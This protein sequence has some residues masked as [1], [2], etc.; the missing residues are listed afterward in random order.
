MSPAAR[1]LGAGAVLTA[2]APGTASGRPRAAETSETVRPR[3]LSSQEAAERRRL[4]GAN[5]IVPEVRSG[6]WRR[7]A[8]AAAD[9]MVFLLAAVAAVELVL[10]QRRDAVILLIAILPIA[11]MDVFLE[12]KSESALAALRRLTVRR[13][14]A[15][16]DGELL[17]L[18][19]TELV[20]GDRIALQEGD[21]VPADSRLVDSTDIHLDE[22]ALTGESEMVSKQ[23]GDEQRARLFAGT[24]VLSGRGSAVVEI[25]GPKTE[26]GKIARLVSEVEEKPTPLQVLLRRLLR[27]LLPLAVLFCVA[28]VAVERLRG[29]PWP[30][31]ILGGLVLAMA[32]VPEEF[33]V[34]FALFLSLGAFRLARRRALVRELTA[35]E[36]LGAATVACV[37]KTGTLT[38]GRLEA[39]F[40]VGEGGR[41]GPSDGPAPTWARRMLETLLL[42]SE[43]EPYDPVDQALSRLAQAAGLQP[44]SVYGRHDLLREHPFDPREKYHTHT[45]RGEGSA[46]AASKGAPET[47]LARTLAH[48]EKVRMESL[49]RENLEGKTPRWIGVA[50]G[51]VEEGNRTP[52]RSSDESAL[53]LIGFVAFHDRPRPSAAEA[54]AACRSA[55]VR[56]VMITGDHAQ[57][58]LAVAR[59]VGIAAGEEEVLTGQQAERLTPEEFAAA[60]GR[61]HV[62]ARA[63]PELKLRIVEALAAAGETVA[64]T[65][66][67][68]NDAP[69]LKAAAIGVSMGRRGT[70]VAREASR[71]VLLDDDF[72]TLV[73]AIREGRKVFEDIRQAFGYLLAVHVPIILLALLPPVLGWPLL[74]L[75]A[76]IVWI[77]LLIHP[78]SSLVFPFEPEPADLMARPPRPAT[79]GFFAPG[80]AR[81]AVLAGLAITAVS[82]FSFGTALPRGAAFARSQA[83]VTLFACFAVLVL[84]GRWRS[85]SGRRRNRA[86]LPV[87]LGTLVTLPVAL[88]FP[89]L[90]STLGLSPL[91]RESLFLAAALA[92]AFGVSEWLLRRASPSLG[93]GASAFSSSGGRRSGRA[94]G[95]A[96]E[97]ARAPS[98]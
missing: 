60:C 93:R 89:W 3:G 91:S 44:D 7:V 49:W 13:A 71:L 94:E 56:V 21:L 58:A 4:H 73:H 53:R 77:E 64:M 39:A 96:G 23:P 61:V 66:D 62:F 59:E 18:P 85:L 98:E 33:P 28:V 17:E 63:T 38:E 22:S 31:S 26:Y 80:Q 52:D 82:I 76:E 30:S 54:V 50:R 55:G 81:H 47:M 6:G 68:I 35:V 10:G 36:T 86:L 79:S 75:P 97:S 25:T 92:A 16:R 27:R 14:R 2:A 32:A 57:T 40:L 8:R 19:A 83:I 67:G 12:W 51:N 90:R 72:A 29:A 24:T 15:W 5:E 84:A 88:W 11:G 65:G 78:T 37:D 74:L 1:N 46:L 9:P 42:A 48:E 95:A 45:W 87:A 43:Q 41:W 69:A 34:V 20:P 70:E